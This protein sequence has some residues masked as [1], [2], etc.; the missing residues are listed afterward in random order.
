MMRASTFS[1]LYQGARLL[2][3]IH[4]HFTQSYSIY[5][6]L[7]EI[8]VKFEASATLVSPVYL[9]HFFILLMLVNGTKPL[10]GKLATISRKSITAKANASGLAVRGKGDQRPFFIE[11]MSME[12]RLHYAE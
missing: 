3:H 12:E 11:W 4:T 8:K 9:S 10:E 2:I 7:K 1:P 5:V 6:L